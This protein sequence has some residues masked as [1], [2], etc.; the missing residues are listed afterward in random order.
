[1]L[2]AYLESTEC[3]DSR[4]QRPAIAVGELPF[5]TRTIGMTGGSS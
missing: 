4:W 2:D 5:D 3:R 1:M